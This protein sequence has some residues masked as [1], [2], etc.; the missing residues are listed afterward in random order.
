MNSELIFELSGAPIIFILGALFHFLFKYGG[1]R[2]WQAIFS[3]VNESLWEHLKIGFF[4][5]IFFGI[6]QFI[7][8]PNLPKNYFTGEI[9]G[10]YCMIL[11][12]LIIESIYPKILKR[13]IL[14]IDFIV[15]FLAI[16]LSQIVSY[17]I[18]FN[19]T[20]YIQ[21]IFIFLVVILQTIIFG[22]FT[23]RTPKLEVFRDS[24]DGIYG[25][26]EKIK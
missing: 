1:K 14:I 5:A 7:L 9:I 21:D 6:V 3:P 23:F 26:K 18:T 22:L 19:S 4:P 8:L 24:V 11:F 12:I 15:F 25:L 20:L 2:R 13:N 10:I 17:L 16:L